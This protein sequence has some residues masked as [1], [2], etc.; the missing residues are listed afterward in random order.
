MLKV[1]QARGKGGKEAREE[2]KIQANRQE[3]ETINLT[4]G[5]GKEVFREEKVRSVIRS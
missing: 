4:A 2:N 3:L 5:L 1:R